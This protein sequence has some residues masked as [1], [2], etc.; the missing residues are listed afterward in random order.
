MIFRMK[1]YLAISFYLTQLSLIAL[2]Q[3]NSYT[4]PGAIQSDLLYLPELLA[5][6]LYKLLLCILI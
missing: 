4:S 2:L 3:E 6:F 1:G 5:I